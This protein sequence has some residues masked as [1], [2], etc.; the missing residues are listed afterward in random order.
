[1]P[2]TFVLFKIIAVET[3][4]WASKLRSWTTRSKTEI[5]LPS[6]HNVKNTSLPMVPRGT[7]TGVKSFMQ[8]IYRSKPGDSHLTSSQP[9][10]GEL[11]TYVSAEY[12]YHNHLE[13]RGP[14][15]EDTPSSRPRQPSQTYV[16]T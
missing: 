15:V 11:L 5:E 10:D 12:D 16:S 8:R 9:A 2:I 14:R 7:M 3:I 13:G 6:Y 1:M 4:S